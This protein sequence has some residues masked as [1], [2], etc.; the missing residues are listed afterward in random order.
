MFHLTREYD[1]LIFQNGKSSLLAGRHG[2][3]SPP[4]ALC[5][6][7]RTSP[8]LNVILTFTKKFV[9]IRMTGR[10][11][12]VIRHWLPQR[13]W[14]S[15]SAFFFRKT[16]MSRDP[17]PYLNVS[18]NFLKEI[19]EARDDGSR[20]RGDSSLIKL[21]LMKLWNQFINWLRGWKISYKFANHSLYQRI[22][23]RG[24]TREKDS[25]RNLL[26]KKISC[27]FLLLCFVVE[28]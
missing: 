14:F 20:A 27:Y 16:L 13:C 7:E 18:S 23:A 24:T 17:S 1:N 28:V 19:C 8:Y 4:L 26:W 6:P 9:R 25:C 10:G 15:K 21:A 11:S 2:L 12:G 22:R 5:H 3:R